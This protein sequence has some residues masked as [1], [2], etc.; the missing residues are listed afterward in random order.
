MA[1]NICLTHHEKWDGSG[2]PCGLKGDEIPWEGQIAAVGDIYDALRSSRAYKQP[3]SHGRA[4][5]IFTRGDGRVEPGHFSP[6]ILDAFVRRS[7][8]LE[9]IFES[10]RDDP[11]S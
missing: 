2:Y 8:D 9:E 7:G 10:L 6:Q 1:R 5:E 3:F 4:M 11:P